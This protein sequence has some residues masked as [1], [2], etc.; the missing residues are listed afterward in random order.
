MLLKENRYVNPIFEW[1]N[2]LDVSFAARS[3]LAAV[4]IAM[5]ISTACD[6]NEQIQFSL[7]LFHCGILHVCTVC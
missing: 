5:S 7:A 4:K 1:N 2:T 6:A 3:L